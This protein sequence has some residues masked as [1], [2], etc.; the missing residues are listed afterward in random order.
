MQEKFRLI[1]RKCGGWLA[2]AT[3][4]CDL[5]IGITADSREAAREKYLA[6]LEE[7]KKMFVDEPEAT[8]V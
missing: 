7:W 4:H 1:E 6:T 5:R 2:V 8:K 3:R